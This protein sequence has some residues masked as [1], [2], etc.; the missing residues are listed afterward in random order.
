VKKTERVAINCPSCGFPVGSQNIFLQCPFCG[1]KS[2]LEV[3]MR[4]KGT[5][6]ELSSQ[7]LST[8]ISGPGISW[9]PVLIAF[10]VGVIFGPTLLTA[11]RQGAERMARMA[12]ERLRKS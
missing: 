10:G 6:V 8:K 2:N 7:G 12:E 3:A 9:M 4:G 11:T 5:S 1:K